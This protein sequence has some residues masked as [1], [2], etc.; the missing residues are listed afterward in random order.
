MWRFFVEEKKVQELADLKRQ[1]V[2][3]YVD[4]RLGQ[5]YS[6]TGVNNDLRNFHTFMVFLQEEGYSVP[7]ALQ[8][9]GLEGTGTPAP[10]SHR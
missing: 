8:H 4:H 10:L 2:M 9:P 5:G 3:D 1:H 6:V 7:L